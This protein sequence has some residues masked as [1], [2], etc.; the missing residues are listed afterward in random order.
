MRFSIERSWFF[1]GGGLAAGLR[2][3]LELAQG[4][5]RSGVEWG[6]G[7]FGVG[8]GCKGRGRRFV[9]MSTGHARGDSPAGY[10]EAYPGCQPWSLDVF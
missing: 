3:G 1:L 9:Q 4:W 8:L 10:V 2:F 5:V 6:L 7:L